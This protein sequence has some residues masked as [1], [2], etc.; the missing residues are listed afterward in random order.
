[1]KPPDV[2]NSYQMDIVYKLETLVQSFTSFVSTVLLTQASTDQ[3]LIA[4]PHYDKMHQPRF[5]L[6]KPTA[7]SVQE[8]MVIESG[9]SVSYNDKE[10]IGKKGQM[11]IPKKEQ[12]K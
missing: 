2:N 7:D 8:E 11:P 3:I 10:G 1:M 5:Y 6:L 4:T 12:S 9:R